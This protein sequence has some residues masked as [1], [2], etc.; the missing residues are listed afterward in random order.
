MTV[1]QSR[2]T[3]HGG[4]VPAFTVDDCFA[5]E[6]AKFRWLW[7]GR[8]LMANAGDFVITR[9]SYRIRRYISL[10]AFI[11][12]L[13]GRPPCDEIDHINRDSTDNR[14]CN[15]RS[16]NRKL[17]GANRVFKP[18]GNGLPQGVYKSGPCSWRARIAIDG[19]MTH[20][21]TFSSIEEASKAYC[22]AR[23]SRCRELALLC[24][25]RA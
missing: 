12:S 5:E 1:I 23:D 11:W 7:T 25:R 16:A 10:H 2:I 6:V 13:S 15:L 24:E 22:E 18:R 21:G 9:R 4:V 3:R 17:N 14:L 8:Y 19:R 20:L